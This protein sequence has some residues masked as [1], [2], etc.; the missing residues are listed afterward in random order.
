MIAFIR[1]T[2]EDIHT[3]ALI[4]SA[5][6]IGYQIY[7]ANPFRYQQYQG[8]TIKIHTY[9]YVR[10]DSVALYGFATEQE[11]A[12]FESLIGVSGIGPKG[13]LA[14]LAACSP[15]D[16]AI[17]V[18][19]ENEKYLTQFPG[20]GKKTARQMIL[21]LK[22]NLAV[23]ETS[24][25]A[26]QIAADSNQ[27]DSREA[28]EALRALGYSEREIQKAVQQLPAESQS[29]DDQVRQALRLLVKQ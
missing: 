2:V 19:N 25:S 18:E 13:G 16:V 1:G 29:T 23:A 15:E 9:H 5:G 11:R 21:D 27:Q 17:A 24:E 7:C 3:D 4:M 10:E 14:I 28:T 26:E 6:G 8:E 22:G 12:L 20:V